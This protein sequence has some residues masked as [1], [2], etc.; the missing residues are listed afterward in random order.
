MLNLMVVFCPCREK[1]HNYA[2]STASA[3]KNLL[4]LGLEIFVG[5]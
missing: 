4:L 3:C 1:H 5:V 2:T